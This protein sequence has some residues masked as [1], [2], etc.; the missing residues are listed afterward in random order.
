M[1]H[2]LSQHCKK[3]LP[4]DQNHF[5][6]RIKYLLLNRIKIIN[7]PL[8]TITSCHKTIQETQETF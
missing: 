2:M 7:K 3:E 5:E 1:T 6:H 4:T 8:K